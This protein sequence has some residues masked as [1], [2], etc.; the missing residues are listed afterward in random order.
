MAW[1]YNKKVLSTFL[2]TA[3][4]GRGP[5]S[6]AAPAGSGSRRATRRR[7]QPHGAH[8]QR[9]CQRAHGPRRH[10]RRRADHDRLHDLNGGPPMSSHPEVAITIMTGGQHGVGRDRSDAHATRAAA[11]ARRGGAAG[12]AGA[13]MPSDA[14]AFGAATAARRADA[15]RPRRA[16]GARPR[17]G[18]RSTAKKSPAK[19]APAK[20]AR[21]LIS[22]R[23]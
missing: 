10:R 23:R 15:A 11:V 8:Q 14:V 22:R 1:Q 2:C 17:P 19:K 16:G 20:R 12:A 7:D 18:R 6:T 13:P 3:P 9:P 5:T 21:P 4:S